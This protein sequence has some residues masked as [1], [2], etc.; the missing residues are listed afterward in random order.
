MTAA[1]FG[2]WG[3]VATVSTNNGA[4]TRQRQGVSAAGRVQAST[5]LTGCGSL[6]P[7]HTQEVRT[8]TTALPTHTVA[9]HTVSNTHKIQA[10]R[11]ILLTNRMFYV[12]YAVVKF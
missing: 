6:K 8:T 7:R 11:I 5:D 10:R 3:P 1:P 2:V 4:R 12:M 9:L